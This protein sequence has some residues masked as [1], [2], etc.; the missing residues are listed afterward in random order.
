MPF[1]K[2]DQNRKQNWKEKSGEDRIIHENMK[3]IRET[4]GRKEEGNRKRRM[5]FKL[6]P[7]QI[8]RSSLVAEISFGRFDILFEFFLH[9]TFPKQIL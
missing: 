9:S 2:A 4:R 6:L 7:L 1:L 8:Q 5:E 3:V